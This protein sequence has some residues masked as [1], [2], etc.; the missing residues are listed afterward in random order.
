[1]AD[2]IWS[3]KVKLLRNKGIEDRATHIAV[4]WRMRVSKGSD[5]FNE[6]FKGTL[7]N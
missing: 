4:H 7:S 3:H 2:N 1:M 6:G 5:S